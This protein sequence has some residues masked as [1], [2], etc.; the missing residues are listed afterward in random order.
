MAD[1]SRWFATMET[2]PTLTCGSTIEAA[3]LR[4]QADGLL[5]RLLADRELSEQRLAA[6]GRRDPIKTVTGV[7]ALERA[8]A[9]TKSMIAEM[10]LLLA[11]LDCGIQHE[12]PGHVDSA[13]GEA[14][15]SPPSRSAPSI[16]HRA[17]GMLVGK[18]HVAATA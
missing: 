9:S 5:R 14:A 6:S 12:L 11:D 16:R 17:G 7:T 18:R 8:I 4:Q 1:R 3:V 10:D 13:N 2:S 15:A